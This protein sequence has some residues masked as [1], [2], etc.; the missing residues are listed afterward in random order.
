MEKVQA[1]FQ[2]TEPHPPELRGKVTDSRFSF[3][4]MMITFI[5]KRMMELAGIQMLSWRVEEL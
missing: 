1:I 3:E 5:G 2:D 4:V